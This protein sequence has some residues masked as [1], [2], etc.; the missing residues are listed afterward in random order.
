MEL[1]LQNVNNDVKDIINTDFEFNLTDTTLVPND[2]D[3]GLTF[4]NG[5]AK[6]GKKLKTCVLFIDIRNSTVLSTTHK[7]QTMGKLYTAFTKAMIYA[8]EEHNGVVRN[9]IGD[10]VMIVFP[11]K[12]CFTNAVN[13]AISMNTIASKII[14]YHFKLNEFKCGIGIAY[15]EML[16]L[17]TGV[18][19]Q[20]KERAPYKNLVWVGQPANV[21]SKLTDTANKENVKLEIEIVYTPKNSFFN[22]YERDFLRTPNK[23]V[24]CSIDE[25]AS[26]IS[27]SGGKMYYKNQT[28]VS[29][30]KVEKKHKFPAILITESA[31]EGYKTANPKDD[32]VLKGWWEKQN[33][34]V[35][36]CT[37]NVY[38]SGLIWSAMENIKR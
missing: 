4:E 10:R 5:Q 13:C 12:N 6:K 22:A 17:K 32:S 31:F 26:T 3:P 11:E 20:G 38:G 37:E 18:P 15:G 14:N 16:V 25:F 9:I 36:G 7:P 1:F 8:A 35:K 24:L 19:K 2:D 34:T 28:I 33:A 29:F 23:T 21:A 27:F 30:S